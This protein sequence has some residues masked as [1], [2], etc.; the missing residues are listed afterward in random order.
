MK[1]SLNEA[2]KA[3]SACLYKAKCFDYFIEGERKAVGVFRL[4][5]NDVWF[6]V[7]QVALKDEQCLV[8]K[9]FSKCNPLFLLIHH[10]AA[11]QYWS[12]DADRLD[13]LFLNREIL[14]ETEIYVCGNE[15]D[16]LIS[17]SSIHE[18]FDRYF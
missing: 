12:C 5:N 1:T 14:E 10:K 11:N 17:T 8:I 15:V 6:K 2:I 13:D 7:P 18:W 3:L 4:L 16:I 9:N